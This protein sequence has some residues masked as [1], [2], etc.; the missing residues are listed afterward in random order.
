VNVYLGK[1]YNEEE[2]LQHLRN[3]IGARAPAANA[4]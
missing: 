3:L 4:G 1:P 2:L